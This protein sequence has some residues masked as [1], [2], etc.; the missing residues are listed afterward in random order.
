MRHRSCAAPDLKLS[1][2]LPPGAQRQDPE[3][4]RRLDALR[5]AIDIPR[6]WRD[7]TRNRGFLLPAAFQRGVQ[8][9]A[10][11]VV[12]DGYVSVLRRVAG[13][14]FAVLN[15]GAPQPQISDLQTQQWWSPAAVE[16]APFPPNPFPIR[17]RLHLIR[18]TSVPSL[19]NQAPPAGTVFPYP[20]NAPWQ[21]PFAG[22]TSYL[23]PALDCNVD[24]LFPHVVAVGPTI[25]G[26]F[27]TW[28]QPPPPPSVFALPYQFAQSWGI[29]D[30]VDLRY[31]DPDVRRIL[32]GGLG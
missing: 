22:D 12:P 14:P 20:F 2:P 13:G 3:L 1:S 4:R 19:D 17:W 18:S 28:Q 6:G 9:L 31:D 30:G 25:V 10:W 24:E 11:H 23:W 7:E 27:A 32:L 8:I 5:P 21:N 26:L 15:P 16:H 29:L